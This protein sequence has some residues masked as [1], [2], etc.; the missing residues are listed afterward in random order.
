LTFPI[1]MFFRM[2]ANY[3]KIAVR[4]IW[5]H[6]LLSSL[7]IASLAFG[8]A[9]CFLI[10]LFIQDEVSFDAFHSN[11]SA[12]YRMDEIQSFP[13]TNT[14][15]VAL[16][17]PGMGPSLHRDYPEVL[18]YTRVWGRGKLLYENKD[19]RFIVENTFSVDSTFLEIFDFE[20]LR[21]DLKT[22]LD[23]P[24]TIVISEEVAQLFFGNSD[25]LGETLKLN[26]NDRKITGVMRNVPENS[27]LQ[28]DILLSMATVT[29]DNPEFNS[30]FG[31]NFLTTYVVFDDHAD[32]REFEK[33]MPEFLTRCQPPEANSGRDIND[34]YKIFFQP[35]PDVHLAS[36]DIEH[37]YLNYRKFNGEFLVIFGF[38]GILILLIAAVNF[39]N[40]ITARASQRG[41]EVGVRKTIGAMKGELFSQFVTESAL[42]SVLAFI[43]GLLIAVAAA[44]PLGTMI[45]RE[46]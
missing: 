33:G 14:Q 31:G 7:N 38:V 20:L 34:A 19:Q 24:Y 25:A 46:L 12:I 30:T 28:F 16:T 32:I 43:I 42:L 2:F 26:E 35:L 39:M 15:N 27:H 29:R 8:I 9:A 17:M 37:D 13:G 40:L 10:Y 18:N 1:I 23:E 21:G 45:G 5:R 6:K 41:K 11:K 3:F 22:A 4:N 44:I 36:M